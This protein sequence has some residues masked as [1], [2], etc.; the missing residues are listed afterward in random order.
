MGDA[1][2]RSCATETLRIIF[3]GD[4]PNPVETE[5]RRVN[6]DVVLV[7]DMNVCGAA[8]DARRGELLGLECFLKPKVVFPG[9]TGAESPCDLLAFINFVGDFVRLSWRCECEE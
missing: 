1:V 9:V 7:G 2:P 6:L 3:V 4:F 8:R 5:A